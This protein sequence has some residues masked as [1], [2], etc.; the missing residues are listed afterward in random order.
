MTNQIQSL[1]SAVFHIEVLDS[2]QRHSSASNYLGI[3]VYV[4]IY[5]F[6]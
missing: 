2:F 4:N 1:A 6:L 5:K 3:L